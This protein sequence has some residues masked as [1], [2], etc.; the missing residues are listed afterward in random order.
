MYAHTIIISAPPRATAPPQ[1][2]LAVPI[3]SPWSPALP[4]ARPV[5]AELPGRGSA[6]GRTRKKEHAYVTSSDGIRCISAGMIAPANVCAHNH[7]KRASEGNGAAAER[8]RGV[9]LLAM[10]PRPTG[11]PTRWS[12]ASG[13]RV[14]GRKDE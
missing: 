12:R 1:K 5:G 3:S 8:P 10:E 13:K 2:G 4:D 9:H 14:G 6:A 7:H 11:C